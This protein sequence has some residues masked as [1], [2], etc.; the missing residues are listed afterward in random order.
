MHFI[1]RRD[2][3]RQL[4]YTLERL[5]DRGMV[6]VGLPRGGVLVASEV[7]KALGVPLDICVIRK[8]GRPLQPEL[9]LGAIGEGGIRVLDRNAMW[10]AGVSEQ[11]LSTV[12]ERERSELARRVA[13]YREYCPAIPLSGRTV[14][15]VDDGVATG[16]CARAACQTVRRLGAAW[17]VLAVPVAPAN[18]VELDSDADELVAV[19]T[20]ADFSTV[21]QFYQD[22][23]Q[24]TDREVMDCLV[25][26]AWRMATASTGRT[27]TRGEQ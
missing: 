21:G 22:F 4:T 25:L 24:T 7:A 20:P 15:V 18:W 13:C 12:E 17:V 26:S 1:N 2:A 9:G 10:L 11:Q 16:N 3:G 23:T 19:Y 8:L 14:I 27:V 5:H 6:V